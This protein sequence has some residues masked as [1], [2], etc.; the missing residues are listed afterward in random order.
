MKTCYAMLHGKIFEWRLENLTHKT[1]LQVRFKEY[2][3]IK[4]YK[5]FKAYI[6]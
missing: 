3:Q 4:S 6:G 5:E 2:K 1:T